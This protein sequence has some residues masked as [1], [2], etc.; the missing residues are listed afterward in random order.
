M[1]SA[2]V[3]FPVPGFPVK[4]ICSVGV[5]LVSASFCRA[6]SMTRSEAISR[7]RVLT[8]FRPTSS[9]SSVP[10]TSSTRAPSNSARN[11][12][13]G[14]AEAPFCASTVMEASLE[15]R[16]GRLSPAPESQEGQA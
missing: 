7:I 13:V 15:A 16:R 12:I 6:L 2:T 14:V 4:D 1:R 8:G 3:V 10:K 5:S 11:R 9:R